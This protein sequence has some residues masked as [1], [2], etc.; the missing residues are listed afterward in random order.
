MWD[1]ESP[2]I[3]KAAVLRRL[4]E[5]IL[6]SSR[7]IGTSSHLDGLS[8]HTA[9][10]RLSGS[11]T[12][13]LMQPHPSAHGYES[14]NSFVGSKHFPMN[15]SSLRKWPRMKALLLSGCG[16]SPRFFHILLSF[17]LLR[18]IVDKT[19]LADPILDKQ[20]V[21]IPAERGL[22]SCLDSD[23]AR[24]IV[25]R[26]AHPELR[27]GQFCLLGKF[28]RVAADEAVEKVLRLPDLGFTAPLRP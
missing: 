4:K 5:R 18:W 21:L 25:A 15:P 20:S 8:P 17:L 26:K 23:D 3:T 13:R 2:S 6:V 14:E 28:L 7:S 1:V 11:S 12:T 19:L 24:R 9:Y 16:K 10:S 22:V 27:R